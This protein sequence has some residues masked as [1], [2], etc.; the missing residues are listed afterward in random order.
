MRPS[1]VL[2]SLMHMCTA[3]HGYG[4]ACA[5]A[6]SFVFGGHPD[7]SHSVPGMCAEGHHDTSAVHVYTLC[8]WRRCIHASMSHHFL[9]LRGTHAPSLSL[10]EFV[11][12][13]CLSVVYKLYRPVVVHVGG[14]PQFTKRGFSSLFALLRYISRA[15]A[16]WAAVPALVQHY[17]P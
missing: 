4:P 9:Y 5:A 16:V 1:C 10:I 12:P 2:S 6:I 7:P 13:F 3:A 11:A 17:A 14:I 15:D 8:R